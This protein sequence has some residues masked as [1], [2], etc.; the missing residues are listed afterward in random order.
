MSSLPPIHAD[1]SWP[2]RCRPV[3]L[4]EP[5][6]LDEKKINETIESWLER[7]LH[8]AMPA[9]VK[10]IL[11]TGIK[12]ADS[13]LNTDVRMILRKGDSPQILA[14]RFSWIWSYNKLHSTSLIHQT[15]LSREAVGRSV[16]LLSSKARK[17]RFG[18]PDTRI[19]YAT[20][21]TSTYPK[22]PLDDVELP[23]EGNRVRFRLHHEIQTNPI[24]CPNN[25]K[26]GLQ[27]FG[28]ESVTPDLESIVRRGLSSDG[29]RTHLLPL[30]EHV[31]TLMVISPSLNLD[32]EQRD[33]LGGC[34]LNI[35]IEREPAASTEVI[36]TALRLAN[37]LDSLFGTVQHLHHAQTRRRLTFEALNIIS[38]SLKNRVDRLSGLY[39]DCA[40]D[41]HVQKLSSLGA[42][43][44]EKQTAFVFDS[45][46]TKLL[47]KESGFL[48]ESITTSLCSS[49]WS[50]RSD[51]KLDLSILEDLPADARW[52]T[53][54][55]ELMA[56]LHKRNISFKPA[57]LKVA[58][59]PDRKSANIQIVGSIRKGF[60]NQV[61]S[62]TDAGEES[63]RN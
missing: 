17:V 48:G 31:D 32:C 35:L 34:G 9:S 18:I 26:V 62:H 60:D 36:E 14:R 3:L 50:D 11:F 57:E 30:L 7:A 58:T 53:I 51:W 43:Q 10:S 2:L 33:H 1:P 8:E 22:T 52:V 39:P 55:E 19:A 37:T 44:I 63:S 23:V 12:R 61:P 54:I 15:H 28:D 40:R 47:W 5:S 21:H 29:Y 27:M 41:L 38:H 49:I 20:L 42:G 4:G 6:R 25:L 56:N 24:K 59:A 16:I 13:R 46:R 45:V